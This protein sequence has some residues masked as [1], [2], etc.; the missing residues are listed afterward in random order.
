MSFSHGSWEDLAL[1]R[2][3]HIYYLYLFYLLIWINSLMLLLI[4]NFQVS[5]G[6]SYWISD[7]LNYYLQSLSHKIFFQYVSMFS[8]FC[9]CFIILLLIALNHFLI[10]EHDNNFFGVNAN[11]F[12]IKCEKLLWCRFWYFFEFWVWGHSDNFY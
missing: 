2:L 10:I 7:F 3:T 5:A 8:T 12:C 11:I 9:C 4:M 1:I 6:L